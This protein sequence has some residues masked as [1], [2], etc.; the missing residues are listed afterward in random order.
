MTIQSVNNEKNVNQVQQPKELQNKQIEPSVKPLDEA[1]KPP[2]KDSLEI[3]SE[4][5]KLQQIQAQVAQGFYNSPDVLRTTATN[6]SRS[7]ENNSN[8][9]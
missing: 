8:F 5:K 6:I 7:L 1:V 2:R 9:E 3:S 4:A